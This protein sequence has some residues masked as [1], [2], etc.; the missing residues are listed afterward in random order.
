M[1]YKYSLNEKYK[2]FQ[3]QV[4]TIYLLFKCAE[5][6]SRTF[7]FVAESDGLQIADLKL[8]IQFVMARGTS[9][10][11]AHTEWQNPAILHL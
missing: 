8:Y 7:Q 9:T 1:L 3:R 11:V 4:I 6:L 2:R 5:N 10:N